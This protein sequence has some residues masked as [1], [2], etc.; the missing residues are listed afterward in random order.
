M[1]AIMDAH[2]LWDAIEPPSEPVVDEKKRKQARAFIF[3]SI[4]E[5]I[6]A[7]ASKKKTAKEVW[8]SLKSRY[9]GAERVQKTR[10]WIL[11]SEFEALQM[12]E[13]E[14]IDDYAGKISAM[15]SK[16]GSAGAILEDEE[17]VR[18]VFDTVPKRFINLVTSNEQSCDMES[19]P[20]E[21][22]IGHLKAYEDRFRLQKAS[23][24][25]YNALLLAKVEGSSTHRSPSK[26]NSTG[27]R[28]RGGKNNRGGRG[29]SRG[30]GSTRGRGGR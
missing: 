7:Q 15:I 20:F 9:V 13:T 28:G 10:L 4:P 26:P 1:D 16:F 11:K 24:Q 19:M 3:W 29:S 22:A 12:K 6:L 18:K 17:L 5:K 14:T 2:G 27:G 25:A 30:R 8:D 23:T 21:E